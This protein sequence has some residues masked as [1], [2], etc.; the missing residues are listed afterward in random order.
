MA[1]TES[2]ILAESLCAVSEL[3][4]SLIYR[5]N[6]GQ[7][8]QGKRMDTP[9]GEYVRVVPGMVILADARPVRFGLVGSG[10]MMGTVEGFA[11]AGETKTLT[12][13]QREGQ[14]LFQMAWQKAGGIYVLAR[15]AQDMVNGIVQCV[16]EKQAATKV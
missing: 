8:W 2:P 7:G 6:T 5:N 11:V 4:R 14:K 16:K 13:P 15:S 12:G 10:D 9:V 3:P 1:K